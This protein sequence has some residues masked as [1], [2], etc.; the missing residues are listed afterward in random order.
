MKTK[1]IC[2]KCGNNEILITILSEEK[3]GKNYPSKVLS[4]CKNCNDE[5]KIK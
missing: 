3:D 4:K 5:I 1:F 2:N